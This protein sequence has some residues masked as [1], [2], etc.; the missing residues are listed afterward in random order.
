MPAAPKRALGNSNPARQQQAYDAEIESPHPAAAAR[1]TSPSPQA[2]TLAQDRASDSAGERT[3]LLGSSASR[4]YRTEA[5][6]DRAALAEAGHPERQ[7]RPWSLRI[8]AALTGALLL[9]NG[10]FFTMSLA[11]VDGTFVSNTAL[12]VHRG[13]VGLPVWVSFLSCTMNTCVRFT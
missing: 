9:A 7:A 1:P 5:A 13:S 8:D 12:P 2:R 6:R 11:S 3:A 4:D 10:Y